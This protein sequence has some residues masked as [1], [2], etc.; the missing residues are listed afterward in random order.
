MDLRV[1]GVRLAQCERLS[2]AARA[3]WPLQRKTAGRTAGAAPTTRFCP[4]TQRWHHGDGAGRAP[5]PK[6]VCGTR[7]SAIMCA[8]CGQELWAG[9]VQIGGETY[10]T[11]AYRPAET[12]PEPYA[13]GPVLVCE[14][15]A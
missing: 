5:A 1:D 14:P 12:Y 3:F 15:I 9:A 8:L 2:P 7:G 13:W 10:E 11:E 4:V 6:D